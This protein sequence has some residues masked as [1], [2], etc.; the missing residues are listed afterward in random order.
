M[1]QRETW[2]ILAIGRGHDPFCQDWIVIEFDCA[3][4]GNAFA[5]PESLAGRDGWC[6]VCKRLVIVPHADGSGPQWAQL[7]TTEQC[8]RLDKMLQYAAG[9]A[10]RF[11]RL[12]TRQCDELGR[13]IGDDEKPLSKAEDSVFAQRVDA[14]KATFLRLSGELREAAGARRDVEAERD[15]LGAEVERLGDEL[16]RIARNVPLVEKPH[17]SRELELEIEAIRHDLRSAEDARDLAE[18]R[19]Q[20]LLREIDALTAETSGTPESDP[21]RARELASL[22][23]ERDALRAESQRMR[24]EIELGGVRRA[25]IEAERDAAH[26]DLRT[27]SKSLEFAESVRR[28]LADECDRLRRAIA[29][30]PAAED[31]ARAVRDA[32]LAEAGEWKRSLDATLAEGEKLL[33]R[34]NA[35][36]SGL[37]AIRAERDSALDAVRLSREETEALQRTASAS[38]ELRTASERDAIEI[39]FLG[40]S[41]KKYEERISSLAKVLDKAF[42]DRSRLTLERDELSAKLSEA[43]SEKSQLQET[44]DT[45]ASRIEEMEIELNELRSAT[46]RREEWVLDAPAGDPAPDEIPGETALAPLMD[47]GWAPGMEGGPAEGDTL[48]QSYLRFLGSR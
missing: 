44:A 35:A 15:A 40:E 21:E 38:A 1:R 22:R 36:E 12:L 47:N 37:A 34:A 23:E 26:A 20:T 41:V 14:V 7:S 3:H 11:K 9:K 17:V 10:D 4:C 24:D 33:L 16:S 31:D 29:A 30:A 42:D 32:A 45:R 39:E 43:E 13:L 27:V 5:V 19:V 8:A 2:G 48:M 46:S 6:R 28:E 18:S 25:E